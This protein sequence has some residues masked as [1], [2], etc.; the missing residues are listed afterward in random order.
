[1]RRQRGLEV[2]GQTD[3]QTDSWEV[4]QSHRWTSV[5][6]YR[7]EGH[8][9]RQTDPG[10]NRALP[11]TTSSPSPTGHNLAAQESKRKKEKGGNTMRQTHRRT[12]T[13]TGRQTDRD[14][15]VDRQTHRQVDSQT[16]KRTITQ[17]IY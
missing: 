2:G 17:K 16:E 3:R 6:A 5:A 14:A 9:Q 4:G 11:Q 15:Q 8:G 10:H 13:Q 12:D 1:M 7:E